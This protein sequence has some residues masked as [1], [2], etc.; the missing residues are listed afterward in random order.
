MEELE[1]LPAGLV[2]GGRPPDAGVSNTEE[3]DGTDWT[4]GGTLNQSARQNSGA[5]TQTAGLNFGGSSDPVS[6]ADLGNTEEYNGT[7]WTASATMNHARSD[8]AQFSAS[9]Q[10]A[11]IALEAHLQLQVIQN[12]IMELVG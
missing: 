2:F 5:G 7:A 9:T 11:G 8:M 10:T 3:Y 12:C 4:N 1:L 6:P